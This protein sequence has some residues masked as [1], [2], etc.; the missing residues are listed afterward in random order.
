MRAGPATVAAAR[1]TGRRP[2]PARHPASRPAS[3]APQRRASQQPA[4][5]PPAPAAQ[6]PAQ[7]QHRQQG[8]AWAWSAPPAASPRA[9][10]RCGCLG[11]TTGGWACGTP[12]RRRPHCWMARRRAGPGGSLHAARAAST[13]PC[14]SKRPPSSGSS[15]HSKSSSS[16]GSSRRRHPGWRSWTQRSRQAPQPHLLT[17]LQFAAARCS[18]CTAEFVP[19]VAC[20]TPAACDQVLTLMPCCCTQCAPRP[21]Y[22]SSAEE[23]SGT[24][25][26]LYARQ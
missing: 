26:R 2:R 7:R 15:S 3:A 20:A 17:Q 24:H 10:G 8:R 23:N 19:V 12:A 22:A 6:V 18:A 1:M 14:S 21:I 4:A 11:V 16:S 13:L 9:C 5:A 25:Q